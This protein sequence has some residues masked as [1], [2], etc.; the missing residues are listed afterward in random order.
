MKNRII[1]VETIK[2]Q[3]ALLKAVKIGTKI[4][5]ILFSNDL[6]SHSSEENKKDAGEYV[7]AEIEKIMKSFEA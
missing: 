7:T 5:D 3:E 6:T 1:L 2:L 4:P